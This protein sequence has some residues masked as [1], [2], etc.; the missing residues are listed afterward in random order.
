[1]NNIIALRIDKF[2]VVNFITGL[3]IIRVSSDHGTAFNLINKRKAKSNSLYN[4][5]KLINKISTDRKKI[6]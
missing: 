2:E 4:C 5:F 3:N 1:M 6:D